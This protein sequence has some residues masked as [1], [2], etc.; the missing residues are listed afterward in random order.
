M[1]SAGATEP[2]S[3]TVIET[4]DQLPSAVSWAELTALGCSKEKVRWLVESGR[5]Q[6]VF[7]RVY[8][9]FSGPIP[10]QVML[11]AAV[12][13]AGKGAALSH[14]TALHLYG[15]GPRPGRIHVTVPFDRKIRAQPGLTIHRSRTL[16][17]KDVRI[18]VPTMTTLERTVV[19]LLADQ[20]SA[21]NALGLVGDA[22]RSRQTHADR[23]R[24]ALLAAPGVKWRKAVL[25][26]LPDVRAG[27]HSVLEIMD[28]KAR[29]RHGLPM[30]E[31][32]FTRKRNGVEH[33]DVLIGEFQTHI[34][35][36]GQLG[37]DGTLEVWRDMDRDNHS[38]VK[39]FRH[40]RYG[41]ADMLDRPCEV[42]IQQAV[43]LRQQ[44]WT[45]EF[46]RCPKCPPTLL[47]GLE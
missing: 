25:D 5:W 1:G 42:M 20:R 36:D 35:M 30:G 15:L 45:G 10:Y 46:R 34:E 11:H 18:V 9:T 38:E 33:L 12:L 14:A 6:R 40:L 32:Q 22:V 28:A 4:A 37:H 27:A 19:D 24:A 26:A 3:V 7:P 17:A 41:F 43:I 29:R 23:L 2:Q 16:S 44:G 21:R 39:R 31:R 13:Y 47:D 8:A